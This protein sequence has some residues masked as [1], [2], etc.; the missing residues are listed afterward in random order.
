MP[1]FPLS[2]PNLCTS[3]FFTANSNI[4]FF[5]SAPWPYIQVMITLEKPITGFSG[6][7]SPHTKQGDVHEGD[8][9]SGEV[10]M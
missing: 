10:G 3:L 7:E 5:F 8:T 2:P 1:L 9:G 4:F 6:L